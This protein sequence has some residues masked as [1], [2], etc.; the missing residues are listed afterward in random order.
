MT[1]TNTMRSIT[2]A[3]E[4]ELSRSKSSFVPEVPGP[5]IPRNYDIEGASINGSDFGNSPS[6]YQREFPSVCCC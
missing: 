3:G 2:T 4:L 6:A 5:D 1:A